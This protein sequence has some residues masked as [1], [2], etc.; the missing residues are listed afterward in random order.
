M[1][2][3]VLIALISILSVNVENTKGI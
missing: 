3:S 2:K 1:K